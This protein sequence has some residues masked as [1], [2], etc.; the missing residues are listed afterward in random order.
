MRQLFLFLL[1]TLSL[2]CFSQTLVRKD[3][4]VK[5][6]STFPK[7]EDVLTKEY[8]KFENF[9]P[10]AILELSSEDTTLQIP[11]I[12]TFLQYRQETTKYFLEDEHCS[13]YS[14]KWQDGRWQPAFT[15]QALTLTGQYPKFLEKAKE[16]YK[17]ASGKTLPLI[18]TSYPEWWQG[19]ETPKSKSG[20]PMTFI[21]QID[22]YDLVDDDA[23]LYVFYDPA[24][25]T[26]KFIYQRD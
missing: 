25:Q 9:F 6:V 20:L 16:K 7:R 1:V 24:S 26:I 8:A 21:C 13:K 2:N 10:L 18:L 5:V 12:Y 4:I 3:F 19:D 22:T 11:I 17:L 14:M 15:S 23:R